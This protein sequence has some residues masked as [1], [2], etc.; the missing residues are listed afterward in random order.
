M[1]TPEIKDQ[2]KRIAQIEM[3]EAVINQHA[4][5]IVLQELTLRQMINRQVNRLAELRVQKLLLTNARRAAAKL[6]ASA[7]V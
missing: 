1:T 5:A 6:A 4:A 2:S 7:A 3:L